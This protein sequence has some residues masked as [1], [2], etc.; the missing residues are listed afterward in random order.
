MFFHNLKQ[1]G[2]LLRN[3]WKLNSIIAWYGRSGC[4]LSYK[5]IIHWI[6][7][8]IDSSKKI[9]KLEEEIADIRF[10][11]EM[12]KIEECTE[13]EAAKYKDAEWLQKQKFVDITDEINQNLK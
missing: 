11:L 13:E 6:D 4:S 9:K 1:L 2:S 3:W 7:G 5:N 10:Y 12:D 8:Q